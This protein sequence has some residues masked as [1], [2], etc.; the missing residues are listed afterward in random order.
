MVRGGSAGGTVAAATGMVLMLVLLPVFLAS[1]L[2]APAWAVAA[3]TA[4]WV[5]LLATG[6]MWF[7][8]RPWR[9][10]V[11]P[12]VA[13]ALWLAVMYVGGVFLGWSA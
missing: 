5:A 3:L 6:V 11:L 12:F 13:A 1:G 10:L 9:V 7:R 8:R 2:L 4:G